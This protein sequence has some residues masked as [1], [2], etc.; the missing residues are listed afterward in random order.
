MRRYIQGFLILC[1]CLSASALVAVAQ[2]IVSGLDQ[3]NFNKF[4]MIESESPDY[5]VK[6]L[7][8]TLEIVSPKGLTLWRKEK[9]KGNVVIEYDACVMDE[10]T[11]EDRLSDLNCFWMASDPKFPDNLKKRMSW[12]SGIFVNSYSLQL[13]YV[14]LGG[15]HN[16][17]TR[18]RRYDGDEAAITDKEKRPAILKEYTDE[19]HLLK[20]NKWYHIRLESMNG[21]VTYTIDGERLVDF[22]DAHPLNEGWFG[23]RTTLS[24]TRIANFR[25]S[26][27]PIEKQPRHITLRWIG[28]TPQ[29]STPNTWGVPF[30]QGYVKPQTTFQLKTDNQTLAHDF[31]PLAYWPDGSVKW[32]AFATVVPGNTDSLQLSIDLKRNKTQKNNSKSAYPTPTVQD[33]K[34]IITTGPLTAHLSRKGGNL[35]DS[36]VYNGVKVAGEAQLICQTREKFFSNEEEK[37]FR[38]KNFKSRINT[39]DIERTDHVRTV[40]KIEGVHTD[41][42]REWLPFV[43]RLYFYQGSEQ[44]KMVHTL[45]YDGDA[46]KDF[47]SA[48]G[49]RFNVPLRDEAY[50]RHIGFTNIEGGVWSEPVQPLT[51]RRLLTLKQ[52]NMQILQMKGERVPPAESFNERGQTLIR[53][54]AAWDGFKLSQL[55]ADAFSIR[56]RA[57]DDSPWIGTLSDRRASGLAFI[58][59]TQGGLAACLQEFWQS[60]P[61]ALEINGARSSE[62]NLTLWLWSPEAEAMDLRHYDKVAHGLN[63]SYEDVQEGLST[64]YGIGR[65]SSLTLTP[66]TY[67]GKE[68]ASRLSQSISHENQL[69]CTPQYLHDRKAFGVWSLP[70]HDTPLSQQIEQHL[71]H[72]IHYYQQA[73]EQHKWYGFWHYGDV[74]HTYDPVR[75]SWQYDVGGFAWDNTELASNMWLW[76]M[77]LRTGRADIWQMAKAMSR[78]TGEVD[79]YH[80]GPHAGLGSRHNVT[81]WGCGAKE[82]R[83]SQ[84]AWNRFYYYLT[85]DERTGDLMT[86]VK[87]AEQKLYTLDPMRLAQPREKYPCTAPARLRIGPDWLAYVSNW[88]TQWERTGDTKY[89]DMIVSGMESIAA[90]PHGI[91][92]GPKALGFDPATGIIT[93]EGDPAMQNTNHLLSIMGGFEIVNEL[94]AMLPH[95]EWERTWLHHAR[96]YHDKVEELKGSKFNIPRLKAYTAYHEANPKAGEDAWKLLLR[97]GYPNAVPELKSDT[98]Q[99]PEVL[100]PQLESPWISTNSTATWSLDAIYLQE[101]WPK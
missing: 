97:F 53:E 86:E 101:V 47:I 67:K 61:S 4:W 76:Y 82:A 68:D 32:G 69:T 28:D 26:C 99:A 66:Y 81:H 98:I 1:V 48:L 39:C 20:P 79:V 94:N 17:T 89:R 63:A 11:P 56:K 34:L 36:L 31:W 46:E 8:D 88:M 3:R 7:G 43:V 64:P 24:R 51:G 29:T 30:E 44:V 90:M 96:L 45:L 58:S 19:A 50:N 80:F 41:R 42:Q 60:Y 83:I 10:G 13:Y 52:Q 75:H 85:G 92:T 54:W 25:Y 2:E 9:M 84:A 87:D 57:T 71:D 35:I 40:V 14:G 72:Y 16:T 12:R 100:S 65:T 22:R 49:V 73:I 27:T 74:M 77:Y 15:N 93:Y 78:H 62:A 37:T 38:Q 59:D 91:F 95:P 21:R 18:F 23:F 6:H 5:R 55:T 33:S 70:K